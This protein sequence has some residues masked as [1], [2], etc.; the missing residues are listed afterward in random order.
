MGTWGA[1]PFENDGALD[2]VLQLKKS[3]DPDFPRNY[4]FG[5]DTDDRIS[6]GDGER[7]V[8]AAE[9]IAASR[10]RASGRLPS[11]LRRWLAVTGT[12]ADDV[13]AEL[14]L[15]V[16]DRIAGDDSGLRW[17]W[18]EEDGT[19]WQDE[20]RDLRR[21]LR[22]SKRSVDSEEFLPEVATR[23]GDVAQLLTSAGKSAYVQVINKTNTKSD[24]IRVMPDLYSPPL[25]DDALAVLVGGETYFMSQCSFRAVL[26]ARGAQARGNY[27]VPPLLA[28]PQPLKLHLSVSSEPGGG[29]VTY[30]GQR[31]SADEFARIHPDIDQTMLADSANIP[32][33]DT[34]LRMIECGWR[35]WMGDDYGWMYPE[36][37]A[38]PPIPPN[39]P[40]PYP[41]SAQAGNFILS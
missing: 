28:G 8:A 38:L 6:A 25:S 13:T 2:W 36:D 32:A 21:R 18:D 23:V 31:M 3:G 20:I 37:P 29:I 27:P 35:P 15:R 30:Q 33:P 7:G 1:G 5:L 19:P 34:L 12:Q 40:A 17:T 22:A 24:L 14:A 10:G 16:V 9:T 41:P 26:N 39:R 11:G 4:L